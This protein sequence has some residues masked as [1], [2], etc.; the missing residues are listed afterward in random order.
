M[1]LRSPQIEISFIS[2]FKQKK[3]RFIQSIT[4]RTNEL[5]YTILTCLDSIDLNVLSRKKLD[6]NRFQF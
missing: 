4:Q 3:N 6:F 5:K 2:K 1:V